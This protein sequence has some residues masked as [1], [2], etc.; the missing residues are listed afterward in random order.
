MQSAHQKSELD[1]TDFKKLED[2]LWGSERRSGELADI[3]HEYL[4]RGQSISLDAITKCA[5]QAFSNLF[6]YLT[7]LDPPNDQQ[8]L[9][10]FDQ[11]RIIERGSR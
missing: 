9:E 2:N 5:E 1:S 3:H 11:D 10:L 6:D 4:Y 8:D 7:I